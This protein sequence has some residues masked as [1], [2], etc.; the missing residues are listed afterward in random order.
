VGV[1]GADEEEDEADRS[2]R[3]DRSHGQKAEQQSDRARRFQG[4]NREGQSRSGTPVVTMPGGIGLKWKRAA[5]PEKPLAAIASSVTTNVG[6]IHRKLLL[7]PD[8][9]SRRWPDGLVLLEDAEHDMGGIGGW[10]WESSR[11][12]RR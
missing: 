1:D 2:G 3:P 9:I 6:G 5:T 4:A 11:C 12:P 10:E 8:S 7:I